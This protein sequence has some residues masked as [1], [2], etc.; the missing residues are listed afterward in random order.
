M[1]GLTPCA[2][3]LGI[4]G[5]FAQNSSSTS[6]F[7]FVQGKVPNWPY[8]ASAAPERGFFPHAPLS[9]KLNALLLPWVE[10]PNP[11]KAGADILNL[12]SPESYSLV[13]NYLVVHIC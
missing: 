2:S 10:L 11:M 12:P 1:A 3:V 6:R 13:T 4:Q 7:L 8:A 5:G 9:R